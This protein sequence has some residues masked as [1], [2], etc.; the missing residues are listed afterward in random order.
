MTGNGQFDLCSSRSAAQ[1]SESR[2]YSF[3]PLAHPRQSPVPVASGVEYLRVDPTAI[4]AYEKPQMAGR[5]FEFNLDIARAGVT[6][7]VYHRFA[8]DPIYFLADHR[9][10][11]LGRSFS[12]HPKISFSCDTEFLLNRGK[13]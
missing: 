12:N 11:R 1:N 6:E 2:A 4:V 10:Q 9:A 13:C 8:A 3:G 7:C 5:I